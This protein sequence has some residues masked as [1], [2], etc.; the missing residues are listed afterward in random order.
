MRLALQPQ[1]PWWMLE[2]YRI[3]SFDLGKRKCATLP[4]VAANFHQLTSFTPALNSLFL[5]YF[6]SSGSF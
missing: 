3:P 1:T 6:I 2:P 5:L 4:L